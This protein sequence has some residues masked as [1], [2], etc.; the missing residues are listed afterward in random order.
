MK[1]RH[2][3]V[4][5]STN[6]KYEFDVRRNITVIQGDS[7]TGK[8]TLIGILAE[9]ANR[10]KDR[11]IRLESDVPCFVYTA[12]EDRWEHELADISGNIVFI[13]EDY[14]FIYSKEFAGYIKDS[15]NY[16]VLIAR[17]PLYYLPYSIQ[18]IYGIR[19][20]GKY[21]FPEQA[22]HEFYP[23]YTES[24][25]NKEESRVLLLVEDKEAGYDFYRN[26]AGD[27]RCTSAEG[28]ANV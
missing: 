24:S 23:I 1:G 10:G 12:A 22:Y 17:K 2:H 6:I 3:I 28:N 15:D 14:R 21:H 7:A 9:Y 25:V 27:Q 26:V 19:T 4:V 13:D 18:E 8:T 11:G 16:Y 20:S 5:E